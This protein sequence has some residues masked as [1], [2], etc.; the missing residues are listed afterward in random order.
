[1]T[2]LTPQG[3]PPERGN[4]DTGPAITVSAPD[5][6]DPPDDGPATELNLMTPEGEPVGTLIYNDGG[7]DWTFAD[8][9]DAD[10]QEY[11]AEVLQYL[12]GHKAEGF[13]LADTIQGI[14]DAYEGD[15]TEAETEY[16]DTEVGEEELAA[17]L[18]HFGQDPD[19]AFAQH[20][21]I[22]YENR[23]TPEV[24]SK[25]AKGKKGGVGTAAGKVVSRRAATAAE[26]KDIAAGRWVRVSSDGKKPGDP[27]YKKNKGQ[28]D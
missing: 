24:V 2:E 12:R 5:E 15:F 25:G 4:W 1:M 14:R 20:D 8:T 6:Y 26:E 7:V 19:A 11:G 27:G 16:E 21:L 23:R 10:A 17:L 3:Y 13:K 28:H 22:F 9:T 18:E